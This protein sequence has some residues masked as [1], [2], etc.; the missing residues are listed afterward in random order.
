MREEGE[1][2]N[3]STNFHGA[4]SRGAA[5]R[6][7]PAACGGLL[8]CADGLTARFIAL[9]QDLNA[10]EV[11]HISACI[12]SVLRGANRASSLRSHAH[13]I[14]DDGLAEE[15]LL[16]ALLE[17][18]IDLGAACRDAIPVPEPVAGIDDFGMQQLPSD[19]QACDEQI[20]DDQG[21]ERGAM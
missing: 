18:A 12:T 13:L 15:I 11:E 17:R 16:S 2:R 19:D 10:L 8:D 7:G 9:Q 21:G 20:R 5:P 4:S 14:T 6:F 3:R 1:D